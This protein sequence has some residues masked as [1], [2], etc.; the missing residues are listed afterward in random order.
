MKE[1]GWLGGDSLDWDRSRGSDFRCLSQAIFC[2]EK[3]AGNLK[4]VTIVQLEKWLNLQDPFSSDFKAKISDAYRI[5]AELVQDRKL[6]KVFKKPAKVS[7]VEFTTIGLLV[8]A[9]KDT[10]T[11]AQLSAAIAKMRE[12]VRA[13]YMDIR[14]NSRVMKTMIDFIKT[15]KILKIPGDMGGPAGATGSMVGLKRKRAEQQDESEDEDDND[16][17]EKT[18][19]QKLKAKKKSAAV[20]SANPPGSSA[21]PPVPK[22]SLPQRVKVE[23]VASPVVPSQVPKLPPPD[24]MAALR[25]A[26]DTIAQQQQFQQPSAL[27]T[28]PRALFNN[29]NAIE[30]NPQ[31]LPSPGPSFTFLSSQAGPPNI[32]HAFNPNSYK[33]PPLPAPPPPLSSSAI[34]NSLMATMMRSTL[35]PSAVPSKWQDGHQQP[36]PP[37]NAGSSSSRRG[38]LDRASWSRDLEREPRDRDRDRDRNYASGSGGSGSGRYHDHDERY[39]RESGSHGYGRRSSDEYDR[40]RTRGWKV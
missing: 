32:N 36:P 31:M 23:P 10:L 1:D 39:R 37:V 28:E 25:R 33:A 7:P 19:G 40:E 11:M 29:P 6:N 30:S 16:D 20:S 12:E 38:S 18:E 14:M 26:K 8:F 5:F 9:H 17:N 4:G 13:A 35:G 24:R 21:V 34:E 15:L 22:A 3:I 2:M 27:P